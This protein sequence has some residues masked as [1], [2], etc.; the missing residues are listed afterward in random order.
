[1]KLKFIAPNKSDTWLAVAIFYLIYLFV[2]IVGQEFHPRLMFT[3]WGVSVRVLAF[4]FLPV[5]VG[6]Y[7]F[8]HSR[9]AKLFMVSAALML[10]PM[11]LLMLDFARFDT[12]RV[13]FALNLPIY[14]LLADG[15]D[16]MIIPR[17]AGEVFLGGGWSRS[18]V[19][20]ANDQWWNK[21]QEELRAFNLAENHTAATF[22]ILDPNNDRDCRVVTP[23]V[24]H[25][26]L[27]YQQYGG[28]FVPCKGIEKR[29]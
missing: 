17:D 19:Y 1:M 13:S 20:N 10:V 16:N 8:R 14:T 5:A 24:G 22:E 21:Y 12:T 2:L 29:Q 27:E 23:L 15:R 11:F 26:Y 25:W 9:H 18:Y 28:G 7:L 4:N 3:A 6:V